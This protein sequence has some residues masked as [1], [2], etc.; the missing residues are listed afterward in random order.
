MFENLLFEIESDIKTNGLGNWNIKPSDYFTFQLEHIHKALSITE[1]ET[2][3]LAHTEIT[4]SLWVN[5]EH[6]YKFN[7]EE[8]KKINNIIFLAKEV[9]KLQIEEKYKNIRNLITFNNDSNGSN[10]NQINSNSNCNQ[11]HNN[12]NNNTVIITVVFCLILK[13]RRI[14]DFRLRGSPI[15]RC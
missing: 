10:C 14:S 2:P 13:A 12:S 9:I 11:L 4:K 15:H 7:P 5:S 3:T 1:K 8:L 6:F